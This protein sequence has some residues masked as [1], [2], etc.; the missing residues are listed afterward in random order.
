M[1]SSKTRYEIACKATGCGWR[2]YARPIDGSNIFSVQ[3]YTAAHECYG[4]NHTGHKQATSTFIANKI[5]EKLQ[6][7]RGYRTVDIR[8]DLQ[9][10]LGVKVT[11]SKAFRARETALALVDGN[12]E[13][14]YKSLPEYCQNIMKTNPHSVVH[15]ESTPEN[16]FRR[17]FISYSA[18]ALGIQY[19]R[20]L[21]G[22]DG[23]HLKT[24]FQGILL[25]ATGVDANGSLYP[26]AYAV[27]DTGNDDNWLWM[28]QYLR[29]IV[30]THAPQ[31]LEPN[32]LTLLSDR[33]KGLIDGVENVFP[34][35]PHGYCLR[36][37]EA[38]FHKQFKHPQL[39]S[40]LWQAARATT[41]ATF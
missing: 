8:K 30:E 29:Q 2:L 26:L 13:D 39:K 27:V 38:N 14:A 16:K 25:A 1:K 33:Q 20:P 21:L 12:H 3:K 5:S 23:T 19:C 35:S 11:Y 24:R 28:L 9:R 17:V 32:V 40:L 7:Q 4:L 18:S 22:L 31:F 36:H 6:Q 15:L 34:N 37:L 41:E 10:E